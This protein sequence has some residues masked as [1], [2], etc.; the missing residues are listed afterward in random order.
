MLTVAAAIPDRWT[1]F[2]TEGPLGLGL[3]LA[4]TEKGT[5]NPSA[6]AISQRS[7]GLVIFRL[8]LAW[9]TS[10]PDVTRAI[11]ALVLDQ[12]SAADV[13]NARARRLCIDASNETFFASDLRS[14]FGGRVP[15]ELVKGGQKLKHRNE[16]LDAKTLLGNLLVALLEDGLVRLPADEFIATDLR[17]VKREAGG[18]VAD[19]G[20]GG[21][22]GDVFDAC[23]LSYWAHVGGGGPVRAEALPV[24]SFGAGTTPRPGIRNPFLRRH[25]AANS[26]MLA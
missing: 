17:L 2:L 12:L 8:I 1:S 14:K 23:K 5:S 9:K 15:V 4:T 18:F 11:V 21:E 20:P 24:G 6:L 25:V 26:G 7:A 3:D 19:T 10:D 22:H 13:A 16:E